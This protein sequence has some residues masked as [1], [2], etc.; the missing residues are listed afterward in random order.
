MLTEDQRALLAQGAAVWGISLDAAALARFARLAALLEQGNRR[1]NLTRIDPA[2]YVTLHFLDSLTL[3]AV[4]KPAPGARLR[5]WTDYRQ[6]GSYPGAGK[7]A[8]RFVR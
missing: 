4:V 6:T 3:A 1:L 5:L 7:P 8:R 2:D